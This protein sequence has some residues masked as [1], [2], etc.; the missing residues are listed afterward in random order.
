MVIIQKSVK[1]LVVNENR[2]M[3]RIDLKKFALV[4]MMSK[5]TEQ[6]KLILYSLKIQVK[7]MEEEHGHEHW[8]IAC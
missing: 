1:S 2:Y 8:R 5:E 6:R 3:K 4:Q 7:N